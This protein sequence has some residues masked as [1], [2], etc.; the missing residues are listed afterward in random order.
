MKTAWLVAAK[1]LRQ[2]LRDRSAIAFAFVAPFLLSLIISFA[3]GGADLGFRATYAVADLDGGDP[4]AGFVEGI[5]KGLGNAVTIKEVAT[6]SEAENMVKKEQAGAALIIPKGFARLLAEG[7]AVSVRVIK[8]AGAPI[9]SSVAQGIAETFANEINAG[10]LAVATAL[11]SQPSPS[12]E[13][14]EELVA[15]ASSERIPAEIETGRLGPRESTSASYF[16]PAM[17]IFF[18]SFT[19]QFGTLG[20]L[21]ERQNHTLSRM[22]AGP[23]RPGS[24]ILGKSLG[25]FI[26]GMIS[27]GVMATA[28]SILL[29][30]NWGPPL[31]V[32]ALGAATIFAFMGISAVG[33]TVA[34]SQE[35]ASALVGILMAVFAIL[36]GNFIPINQ[37]PPLMQKLSLGTPNGWAMRGFVDLTTGGGIASLQTPVLSLVAIGVVTSAIAMFRGRRLVRA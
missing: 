24:I 37:A 9:S 15:K 26:L 1:D 4:S 8:G 2:R 6:A 23:T 3:F 35:S 25:A 20:L 11:D 14:I 30:A 13:R 34:K 32:A 17:A 16:G 5:K 19:V 29:N 7:S 10:R 12:P 28:T 33:S 31:G 21:E 27:L 18:L 36:G 22:L